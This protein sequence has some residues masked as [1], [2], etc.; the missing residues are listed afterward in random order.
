MKGNRL[1]FHIK[2]NV[3]FGEGSHDQLLTWR[4]FPFNAF[5]FGFTVSFHWSCDSLFPVL[6]QWRHVKQS[7]K[8]KSFSNRENNS[9][10]TPDIVSCV[11]RDAQKN[12]M[13]VNLCILV[14][15]LCGNDWFTLLELSWQCALKVSKPMLWMYY[16]SES[17]R[18]LD[19]CSE[20]Q[21]T[22]FTLHCH[23][24]KWIK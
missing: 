24:T 8:G 13:L 19:Q 20:W 6:F 22:I 4:I 18:S 21:F 10:P 16:H 11:T 12:W 2:F 7:F 9:N 17:N 5:R 23:S 14:L 15:F 1:H 3:L